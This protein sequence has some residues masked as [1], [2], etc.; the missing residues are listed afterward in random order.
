MLLLPKKFQHNI[1]STFGQKGSNWLETLPTSISGYAQLW[2]LTIG[3]PFRE[4]SYNFV[5][6][7]TCQDGS[8]VVLKLGVPNPELTSEIEALRLYDGHGAARLLDADPEGGALLIEQLLPG[9]PLANLDDDEH[10]TQIAAEIMQQLWRPVPD[11]HNLREVEKWA[12]GMQRLRAYYDG[13]TGPFPK[14]LTEQAEVIFPELIAST[15][16]QMVLHGDLHHGNILS[17]QRQSWLALDPK[18]VVGDPAYEVTAW[19]HNPMP[20]LNAWPHLKQ[21]TASRLD[22]FS[23]IL[24]FDRQRLRNWSLAQAVLS[25]WWCIEDKSNCFD[26]AMA[27]AE[28]ISE[29]A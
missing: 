1:A 13:G 26:D 23:E 10:A 25:A 12:F 18:G 28:I 21:T 27:V 22:Q 8:Q 7:A 3:H 19:M 20:G 5:T 14:K 4:M 16:I 17:A 15:Q 24:G 29:L 9:I 6:R 2:N 11:K